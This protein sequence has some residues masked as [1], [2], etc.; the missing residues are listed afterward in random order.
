KITDT[1]GAVAFF[2]GASVTDR[3]FPDFSQKML[4]GTGVGARYY[5]PIG[6]VRFDIAFPLERRSGDAAFQ[7]Y[8][9]L[10]QAF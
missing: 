9:S 10:G 6:P 1:I 3:D 5:S 7:L 8:I 2:E 4:W